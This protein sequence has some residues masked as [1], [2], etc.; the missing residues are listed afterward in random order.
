M[1]I[2]CDNTWLGVSKIKLRGS[3]FN[4]FKVASFFIKKLVAAISRNATGARNFA[5]D[6]PVGSP[7]ALQ[8][9]ECSELLHPTR[10]SCMILAQRQPGKFTE[11]ERNTVY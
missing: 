8:T 5:V 11:H 1:G 2:Q 7:G 6:L 9:S 3:T 10:A 4:Y